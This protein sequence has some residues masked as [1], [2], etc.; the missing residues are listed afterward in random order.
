M[1]QT[2]RPKPASLM[3]PATLRYIQ[4]KTHNTAGR[5]T[6]AGDFSQAAG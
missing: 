2:E 4:V 1:N 5:F 3:Q 6:P